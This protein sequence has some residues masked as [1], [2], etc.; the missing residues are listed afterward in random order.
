MTTDI[1][2]L[3]YDGF[4]ELDAIAPYEVFQNAAALGADFSVRLVTLDDR[5]QV[6]ASHG[7]RVEPDGTLDFDDRPDVLVVP[8]GGWNSRSEAG[9]W[10][11]AERGVVPDAVAT[12]HDS[13]V[14]VASVCTGGMLLARA[15]LT[16]GRPAVTHASAVDDLRDSG[17][18]VVDA[19]VVDDGDLLTAGGVTSGLDLALHLVD[20]LAGSAIA[21]RV[22]TEIEYERRFEVHEETK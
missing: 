18:D 5:T 17:A 10:A 9:A 22:A 4:D 1:A 16:D 11:E 6:T 12:L 14:T 15:G 3:L 8:G 20:R 7:L 13:G 2:I 19:R 21:D